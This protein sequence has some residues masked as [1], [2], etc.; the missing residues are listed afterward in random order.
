[1]SDEEIQK[2][3]IRMIS[4]GYCDYEIIKDSDDMYD[5]TPEEREKCDDFLDEAL[6]IGTVKFR[7]KYNLD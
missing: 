6:K 2:I 4:K 3:I 7:G 1:M 5:A